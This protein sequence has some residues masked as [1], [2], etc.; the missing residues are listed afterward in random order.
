MIPS[1]V[2]IVEDI[3]HSARNAAINRSQ[4]DGQRCEPTDGS[5]VELDGI[6][7]RST[8]AIL[9]GNGNYRCRSIAREIDRGRSDGVRANNKRD[10]DGSE[11]RAGNEGR[12]P[13][14]IDA[15]ERA[16][17]ECAGDVNSGSGE[18]GI[19]DRRADGDNRG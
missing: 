9:T 8:P 14:Y 5:C 4:R 19:V 2:E 16:F 17:G 7:L 11:S 10:V 18:R 3:L 6:N 13:V 15:S 1:P 12:N